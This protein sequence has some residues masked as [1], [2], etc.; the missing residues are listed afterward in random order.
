MDCEG[1]FHSLLTARAVVWVRERVSAGLERSPK[2][3]ITNPHFIVGAN[4]GW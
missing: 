2:P 4:E 1:F 3:A